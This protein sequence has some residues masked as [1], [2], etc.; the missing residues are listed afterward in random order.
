MGHVSFSSGLGRLGLEADAQEVEDP[1]DAGEQ[2]GLHVK[3]RE[4][5]H[6]QSGDERGVHQPG[7]WLGDQGEQHGRSQGEKGA[8]GCFQYMTFNITNTLVIRYA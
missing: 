7:G 4:G 8:E 1:E 2:H 3:G 5:V 6:P